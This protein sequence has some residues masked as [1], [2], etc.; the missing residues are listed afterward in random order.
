VRDLAARYPDC[1]AVQ[2]KACEL[3]MRLGAT[4]RE[5]SQY[6]DRMTTLAVQ[7]ACR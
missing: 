7:P 2:H 5:L 3:A 1:Y 4:R 6:C